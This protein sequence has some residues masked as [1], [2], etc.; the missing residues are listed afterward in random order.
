[1]AGGGRHVPQ[2][3]QRGGRQRH[4]VGPSPD[5]AVRLSPTIGVRLLELLHHGALVSYGLTLQL[6][7]PFTRYALSE[8]L[9]ELLLLLLRC[10]SHLPQSL[11]LPELVAFAVVEVATCR[12][13]FDD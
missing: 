12:A 3:V 13:R 8:V 9:V 7:C 10:Q 11:L 6:R 2:T 4:V 1:M 5:K